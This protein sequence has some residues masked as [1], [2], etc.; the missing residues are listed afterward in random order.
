MQDSGWP[1]T[2]PQR[3]APG[4]GLGWFHTDVDA[5]MNTDLLEA[6]EVLTL[7]L[8]ELRSDVSD[9]FFEARDHHI[10]E[11]IHTPAF[12]AMQPLRQPVRA[13]PV[14]SADLP[15]LIN[16]MRAAS[17]RGARD[18]RHRFYPRTT[19]HLP[20]NYTPASCH[21]HAPRRQAHG[22]HGKTQ[23]AGGRRQIATC[24]CMPSVTCW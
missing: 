5:D 15:T 14:V 4:R 16:D 20:T 10:L 8:V 22:A 23:E 18:T 21:R 3:H 1:W 9:R 6:H 7:H 12:A 19:P 24:T 11:R 2:S 17:T 13:A